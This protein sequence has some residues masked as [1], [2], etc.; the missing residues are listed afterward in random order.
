MLTVEVNGPCSSWALA[1]C[2]KDVPCKAFFLE[3][4][5]APGRTDM[6]SKTKLT[7]KQGSFKD[8]HR[9]AWAVSPEALK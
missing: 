4:V 8:G 7:S 3:R 9:R 1:L 6:K 2:C 5:P